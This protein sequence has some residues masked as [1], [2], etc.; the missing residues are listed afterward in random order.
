MKNWGDNVF[1]HIAV[2]PEDAPLFGRFLA[3]HDFSGNSRRA[4]IQDVRK[5]ARW[6]ASANKEP[7]RVE[8]CDHEAR[9]RFPRPPSSAGRS[10][11]GNSQPLFGNSSALLWLAG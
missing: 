5:F 6:F 7:F 1:D 10:S 9:D 2:G 4:F 3:A 11:G 8:P